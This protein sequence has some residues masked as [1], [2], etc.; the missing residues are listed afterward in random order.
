MCSPR[1]VGFR[2]ALG[3]LAFAAA[4][5]L[6]LP[7]SSFA[8]KLDWKGCTTLQKDG[9]FLPAADCY[10]KVG[11]SITVE[12]GTPER[13]RVRKWYL[14]REAAKNLEKAAKKADRVDVAGYHRSRAVKL[15][16]KALQNQWIPKVRG[17]RRGRYTRALINTFLEKIQ[18]TPLGVS[19]GNSKA[20]IAVKGYKYLE[21]TKGSFNRKIRPGRYT[22]TVTFPNQPPKMK[23]VLIKAKKSVVLTFVQNPGVPPLA[24]VGYTV[25]SAAIV[26]GG[27]L[28]ALGIEQSISANN[29]F[30]STTCSFIDGKITYNS[31][32]VGV[33]NKDA[34]AAYQNRAILYGVIGGVVLATGVVLLAVGG[35]QHARNARLNVSQ[36]EKVVRLPP[37]D[38]KG[39]T[40][41][42]VP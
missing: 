27:V 25:G 7:D 14:Y 32:A 37:P 30:N 26:G 31:T 1:F 12:P 41:T 6:V 16:K 13:L 8:K 4:L 42:F 23:D 15:L 22:V 18:Y 17:K 40:F 35:S 36:S 24:W 5:G 28:M 11:N 19:T 21:S 38:P 2:W 29:C 10:I 20:V 39:H 34:Y 33:N 9:Y 3:W